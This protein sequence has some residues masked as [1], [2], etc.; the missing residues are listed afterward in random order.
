VCTE[1]SIR[2]RCS[3][4]QVAYWKQRG[5]RWISSTGPTYP[6]R[7]N[8]GSI[9]NESIGW[10]LLRLDEAAAATLPSSPLWLPGKAT[11]GTIRLCNVKCASA[12]MAATNAAAI[13]HA[14]R[15]GGPR[16][17]WPELGRKPCL[18][19]ACD[20][21]EIAPPGG[22]LTSA[23]RA[24][25]TGFNVGRR[26][27]LAGGLAR[28]MGGDELPAIARGSSPAGAHP[29]SRRTSPCEARP[30]PRHGAAVANLVVA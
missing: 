10:K 6:C 30:S 8:R 22:A 4:W 15:I 23:V 17:A 19:Q 2:N 1:N 11:S 29:H 7:G 12:G 13:S 25:W 27:V 20:A 3:K 21:L 26:I 24:G 14:I 18:V 9:S 28:R 16:S 5:L